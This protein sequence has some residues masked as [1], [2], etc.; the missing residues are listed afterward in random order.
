MI[1]YISKLAFWVLMPISWLIGLFLWGFITKIEKRRRMLLGMGLMLLLILSN[2]F[3]SNK[4]LESFEHPMMN[5]DTLKERN[6]A[7]LLT[8]VVK[9]I[10][11]EDGRIYFSHG[12]DRVFHTFQLYK[13]GKIKHILVSGGSGELSIKYKDSEAKKIKQCLLLFGVS[14]KDITLEENSR[15]THE[16]A[17]FSCGLVKKLSPNETPLLVTSAFHLPRSIACFN[18]VG[19]KVEP[20]SV[21][22]YTKQNNSIELKDFIPSEYAVNNWAI[23]VHEIIGIVSYT[24]LGYC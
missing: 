13:R 8:G 12:A 20:V 24:L 4:A 22:Y 6:L 3:L 11:K 9:R 18:K 1:F 23:L 5:I 17:L 7:I 10:E 2:P 19:I 16:N 15:N 14:E 21:D